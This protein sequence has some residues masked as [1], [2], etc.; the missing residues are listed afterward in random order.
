[1]PDLRAAIP[2]ADVSEMSEPRAYAGRMKLALVLL[3]TALAPA[4]L[5]SGDHDR[6]REAV[7][8]REV[9]PLAGIIE[10]VSET[11]DAHLLEAEFERARGTLLYELKLITKTGQ[12]IEVYVDA[13]TGEIVEVEQKGWHRGGK[14]RGRD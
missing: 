11:F 10:S 2:A 13:T 7:R 3:L 1:M 6:V 8:G 4:A 5:A 12:M 14:D 9:L